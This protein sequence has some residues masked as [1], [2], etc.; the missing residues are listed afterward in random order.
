MWRFAAARTIGTSHLRANV[1]CQDQL[2]C[3]ALPSDILAAAI[4]DGA[5]SAAKAEQGANI[6]IDTVI[7]HLKRSLEEKRSD[8]GALLRESAA[9]ARETI[10]AEAARK[11]SELRSY[12]STLLAT[13]TLPRSVP[14]RSCQD[15][16]DWFWAYLNVGVIW[17]RDRCRCR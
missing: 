8:F 11:G 4:A 10:G 6:A 5:G 2:A 3:V 14:D 12:A 9:M 17:H 7:T 15:S 13:A 16:W 1:P